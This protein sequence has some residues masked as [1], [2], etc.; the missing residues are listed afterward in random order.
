MRVALER[1]AD[2]CPVLLE[3]SRKEVGQLRK[4]ELADLQDLA[5]GFGADGA[6]DT[7]AQL[8]VQGSDSERWPTKMTSNGT[9]W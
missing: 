9:A 3:I 7:V 1:T 4:A 6:G 5:E 8:L 2:S